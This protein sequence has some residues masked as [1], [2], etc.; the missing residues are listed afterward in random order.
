MVE[1]YQ[2]LHDRVLMLRSALF[3]TQKCL[4]QIMH[5]S[6]DM[7]LRAATL[8]AENMVTISFGF[9]TEDKGWVWG[10]W[11][12]LLVLVLWY[13]P[14]TIE[15]TTKFFCCHEKTEMNKVNIEQGIKLLVHVFPAVPIYLQNTLSAQPLP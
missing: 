13:F 4:L 6:E 11:A 3:R 12:K 15:R 10:H 5:T 14:L 9:R 7:S 2:D 8:C 1:E